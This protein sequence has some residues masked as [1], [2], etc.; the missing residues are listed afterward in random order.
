MRRISILF[1]TLGIL[2][3]L[4]PS[5]RAQRE[6]GAESLALDDGAGHLVDIKLPAG[7]TGGP[8]TW[9]LP[10]TVPGGVPIVL[11]MGTTPFSTLYWNA[12]TSMWT[13]NTSLTMPSAGELFAASSATGQGT[14]LA[15]AA[16]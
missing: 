7:L 13:E 15:L 14:S 2:S 11:P 5:L 10:I 16:G 3:L 9:F 6:I 12:T 1:L 8:Y 4:S